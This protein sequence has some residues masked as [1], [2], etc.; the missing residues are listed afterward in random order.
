MKLFTLWF[1]LPEIF[2]VFYTYGVSHDG[3][4]TTFHG[5]MWLMAIILDMA[6]L[7]P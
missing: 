1:I 4:A 3:L 6:A 7:E 5:Y 2:C